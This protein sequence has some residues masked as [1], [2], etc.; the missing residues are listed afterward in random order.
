MK[1]LSLHWRSY[2]LGLAALGLGV[3]VGT[4]CLGPRPTGHAQQVR[5]LI[6]E[7]FTEEAARHLEQLADPSWEVREAATRWLILH[8]GEWARGI[9]ADWT[10]ADPEAAWRYRRV[11]QKVSE[12]ERF[13]EAVACEPWE[14]LV[15]QALQLHREF[16][17]AFLIGLERVLESP[18]ARVRQ[19][20]VEI[21]GK[22]P[23]VD[24]RRCLEQLERD[25]SAW[26]RKSVYQLALD[27]DRSWA[28]DFLHRALARPETPELTLEA[29]RAIRQL[30]DHQSVRL[31]RRLWR[32]AETDLKCEIGLTLCHLGDTQDREIQHWM[33][34]TGEYPL[35]MAALNE[36]S[37]RPRSQDVAPLIELL[38]SPYREVRERAAAVISEHGTAA[39]ALDLL[40]HLY[41]RDLEV[42]RQAVQWILAWQAVDYF[43][44]VEIAMLSLPSESRF[45]QV[46]GTEGG[47]AVP[48]PAVES[49]GRAVPA[50][51]PKDKAGRAPRE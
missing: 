8:P 20:G 32:R 15:W 14:A 51:A 38:A 27:T 2:C 19:R 42:V 47:I 6:T 10:P 3:F 33:L 40:P 41:S 4:W 30:G 29:V 25:P 12:I 26:V 16:E 46:K 44:D 22:L 36:V 1:Q 23:R 18:S 11:C 31:L 35:V 28:R 43:L 9:P 34:G 24:A 45:L 7:R 37:H 50:I 17:D 48:S 49:Q 5:P 39:N 21:L 13:P